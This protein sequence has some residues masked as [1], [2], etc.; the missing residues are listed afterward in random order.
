MAG[1]F[2]GGPSGSMLFD[3]FAVFWNKSVGT[4]APPTDALRR[5]REVLWEGLSGPT[6]FDQCAVLWNK[7]VGAEAPPTEALRRW[8]EVFVGGPS[9]PDALRSDRGEP[10]RARCIPAQKM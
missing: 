4:E 3:R 8:R 9:R 7:S 1:G 5:W 10:H 2:V 6:L